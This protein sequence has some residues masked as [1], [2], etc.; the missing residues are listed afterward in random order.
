V[1]RGIYR[2]EKEQDDFSL[3]EVKS[4]KVLKPYLAVDLSSSFR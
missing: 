3:G 1:T 2:K 4:I